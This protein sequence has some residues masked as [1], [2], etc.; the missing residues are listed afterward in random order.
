[1]KKDKPR[2]DWIDLS[3][4]HSGKEI[5]QE[6]YKFICNDELVAE[7]P[8]DLYLVEDIIS[9]YLKPN[10]LYNLERVTITQRKGTISLTQLRIVEFVNDRQGDIIDIITSNGF[11]INIFLNRYRDDLIFVNE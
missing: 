10:E 5:V 4:P 7:F 6:F 2:E 3:I 1:M 11:N 8:E 9:D